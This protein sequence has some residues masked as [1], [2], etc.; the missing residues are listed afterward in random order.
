M[1]TIS[2]TDEKKKRVQDLFKSLRE[3]ENCIE[4][5]AEQRKE[6]RKHYIE[7]QWL[8]NEEFSLAKRAFN[9]AKKKVDVD[10]FS[11]FVKIAEEMIP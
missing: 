3:I 5:F 1:A 2:F 8:S 10:D 11:E 4:P 6:L 7:N 9:A